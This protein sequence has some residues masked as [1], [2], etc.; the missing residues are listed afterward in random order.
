MN[1]TPGAVHLGFAV[2]ECLDRCLSPAMVCET[3]EQA[4]GLAAEFERTHRRKPEI[5]PVAIVV[6]FEPQHELGAEWP[7]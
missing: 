6:R 4:H 1:I 3:M 7:Q 5:R 2:G